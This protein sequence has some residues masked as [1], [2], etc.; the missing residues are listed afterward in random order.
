M[1]AYKKGKDQKAAPVQNTMDIKQLQQKS[2]ELNNN[3]SQEVL[4]LLNEKK[5]N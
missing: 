2:Y 5:F 4:P 1:Q 3:N